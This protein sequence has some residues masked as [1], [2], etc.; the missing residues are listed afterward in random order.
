MQS[1]APG[2]T[3]TFGEGGGVRDKIP[4]LRITKGPEKEFV[5]CVVEKSDADDI[6]SSMARAG[7]ITEPGRGFMYSI[8]VHNGLINVSS[9]VS[10]S[11]H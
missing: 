5:W 3:V 9:T 8:P 10:S 7:K 4:L 11:A 1:G 2:P 6:F